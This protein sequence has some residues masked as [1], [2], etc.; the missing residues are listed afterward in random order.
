[1]RFRSISC[2]FRLSQSNI[3]FIITKFMMLFSDSLIKPVFSIQF[4]VCIVGVSSTAAATKTTATSNNNFFNGSWC[5][6]RSLDVQIFLKCNT[7]RPLGC[8]FFIEH[9]WEFH[10]VGFVCSFLSVQRSLVQEQVIHVFIH[11]NPFKSAQNLISKC[12]WMHMC[13][14]R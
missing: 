3:I 7:I 13:T 12:Q 6:I 4:T 9:K 10:F 2:Y 11:S 5:A 8:C 1:M 14:G